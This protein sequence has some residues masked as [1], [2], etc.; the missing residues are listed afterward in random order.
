MTG[1]H[2]PWD[3]VSAFSACSGQCGVVTTFCN[4]HH[5]T[6]GKTSGLRS[7]NNIPFLDYLQAA[8]IM[9][10]HCSKATASL[11]V[12][13]VQVQRKPIHSLHDRQ[14]CWRV[15]KVTA[16]KRSTARTI[17]G[18]LNLN[19]IACQAQGLCLVEQNSYAAYAVLAQR[20]LPSMAMRSH[21]PDTQ[22]S[23]ATGGC[24]YN[25]K[26]FVASL[27]GTRHSC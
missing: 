4:S 7:I 1:L 8:L 5:D 3:P 25:T 14:Q 22:H 10:M 11:Q 6:P 15:Y 2:I 16:F 19:A 18:Q 13:R 24:K 26:S 27:H 17:K 9:S 23:R 20:S 12:G 21:K